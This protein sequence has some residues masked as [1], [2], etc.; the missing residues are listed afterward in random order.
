MAQI[1]GTIIQQYGALG[2]IILFLAGVVYF[3]LEDRKN[4]WGGK[5]KTLCDKMDNLDIKIGLVEDKLSARMDIVESKVDNLPEDSKNLMQAAAKQQT[6]NLMS[7]NSLGGKI[8]KVL[9]SFC[10]RINCDHIFLG[11]FHNGTTD[12]RGLHY[13]KF[14]ILIDEF[15]NPLNLQPND[16]DFQPLYK[17]ENIMAYGDLPYKM[18]HMDSIIINV[19][20]ENN[21]L[22]NLSD[23]MYRRCKSRDIKSIGFAVIRDIEDYPIGFIGCVS[24][25]NCAQGMNDTELREC[26][27]EIEN[28]YNIHE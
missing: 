20:D 19:D 24:Y 27:H 18:I 2:I 10:H 4:N 11:S 16:I 7:S 14:D 17:D 23:T 15:A 5:L 25:V 12:L 1:I 3:I 21:T 28:I 9:K 13:C 6:V 26:A 22:F 8:S